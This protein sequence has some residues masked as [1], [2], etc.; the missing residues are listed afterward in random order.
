MKIIRHR[1]YWHE[2]VE[3]NSQAS[4]RHSLE[5]GIGLETDIRDCAGRLVVAHDPPTS[6]A[7]GVAARFDLYR[8]VGA[9]VTLALNI[10]ADGLQDL[11]GRM[12][13]ELRITRYFVFDMSIPDMLRWMDKGFKVFVRQS[14]YEPA[15]V[16]YEAASE[17][18]FDCFVGDWPTRAV[19]AGHLDVGKSVCLISPELHGRLFRPFWKRLREMPFEDAD[20]VLLCTD[21]PDEAIRW[22]RPMSKEVA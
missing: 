10:K 19:I 3:Q 12:L 22:F 9:D 8:R 15:P 2:S 5:A 16:M 4:F 1:G 11:L 6:D 20:D 7:L 18:V 21:H 13:R 17:V 14:E